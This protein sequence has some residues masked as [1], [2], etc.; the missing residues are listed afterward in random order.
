MLSF[1]LT[2]LYSDRE[3]YNNERI[4]CM[5]EFLYRVQEKNRLAQR[6]ILRRFSI[7]CYGNQITKEDIRTEKTKLFEKY[8]GNRN[9]KEWNWY[10]LRY[11][12][13]EE[14]EKKTTKKTKKKKKNKEKEI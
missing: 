11:V 14:K 2:F 8:K 6:G 3:Y 5:S 7:N 10:F 13:K 12:P 4:I 9:S 1:Y